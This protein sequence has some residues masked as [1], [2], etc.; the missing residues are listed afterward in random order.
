MDDKIMK[1]KTNIK[2]GGCVAKVT[3]FL[4]DCEGISQWEV[5]TDVPEKI[6]TVKSFGVNEDQV[7]K[8]VQDAG[9]SISVLEQ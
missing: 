9:F 4:N 2:C 7:I 6:L 5:D 3:P 1:F 8:K